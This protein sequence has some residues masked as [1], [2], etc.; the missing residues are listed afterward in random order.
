[1][2]QN[3]TTDLHGLTDK[4]N[5]RIEGMSIFV[6]ILNNDFLKPSLEDNNRGTDKP[7]KP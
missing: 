5:N 2:F 3:G 4:I 1:M 6:L 7:A